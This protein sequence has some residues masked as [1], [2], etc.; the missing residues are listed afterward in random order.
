MGHSIYKAPQSCGF[1]ATYKTK[2]AGMV[3]GHDT[4]AKEFDT[5]A[6]QLQMHDANAANSCIA[7][8]K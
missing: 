2:Y 8:K 3:R 1:P 7:H 5:E 6:A 4:E